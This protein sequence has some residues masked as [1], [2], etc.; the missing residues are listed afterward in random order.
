MKTTFNDRICFSLAAALLCASGVLPSGAR[1]DDLPPATAASQ[2]TARASA[3]PDESQSSESSV[4][5]GVI[6]INGRQV[7]TNSQKEYQRVLKKLKQNPRFRDLL[8]MQ[9]S[10]HAA[11]SSSESFQGTISINGKQIQVDNREEFERLQRQFGLP[12]VPSTNPFKGNAVTNSQQQSSQS[13]AGVVN[14]NGREF[15]ANTPAEMQRLQR[16]FGLNLTPLQL[17]PATTGQQSFSGQIS[18]NGQTQNF[19]SAADFQKAQQQLLNTLPI[20]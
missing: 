14:I 9:N 7:R 8:R 17:P 11:T 20:Q 12:A 1:A 18:V 6:S 13:F 19:S 10:N 2:A 5:D 15:R 16:R 3:G 4:F